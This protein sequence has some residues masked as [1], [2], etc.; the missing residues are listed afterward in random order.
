MEPDHAVK[1]SVYSNL[2]TPI[3]AKFRSQSLQEN[4]YN[5]DLTRMP[6]CYLTQT[7]P[8]PD[9]TTSGFELKIMQRRVARGETFISRNDVA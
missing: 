8:A 2:I 3:L 4:F 6:K 5:P 9:S 7:L 1:Q